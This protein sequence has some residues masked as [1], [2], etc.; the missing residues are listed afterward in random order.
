[1]PRV[2]TPLYH[3]RIASSNVQPSKYIFL[4]IVNTVSFNLWHGSLVLKKFR[5]SRW[6]PGIT[7][8][9][10]IV[11]TLMGLVKTFVIFLFCFSLWFTL[12][13]LRY[14]QLVGVRVCLG[15]AE[16]GLFPGVVY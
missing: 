7:I 14:P 3:S 10:G 6:L 13:S 9:W 15:V 11:M 1:M 16:A 2:P 4:R 8:V 5:P 12:N